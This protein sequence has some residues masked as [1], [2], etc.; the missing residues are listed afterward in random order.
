[1]SVGDVI[2]VVGDARLIVRMK[3]EVNDFV[4]IFLSNGDNW[5]LCKRTGL[6]RQLNDNE[7]KHWPLV[8]WF[9]L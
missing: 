2:I 4:E 9:V 6:G 1:M 8:T 3:P 7:A 5:R